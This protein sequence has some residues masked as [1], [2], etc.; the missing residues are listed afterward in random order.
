MKV[1]LHIDDDKPGAILSLADEKPPHK[2]YWIIIPPRASS[3]QVANLLEETVKQ[4]RGHKP[5]V[6]P[7]Q[8]PNL[9]LVDPST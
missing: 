5:P 1:A 8:K 9:S 7:K 2:T 4:I 3:E 6:P